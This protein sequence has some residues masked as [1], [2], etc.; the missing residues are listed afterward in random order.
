MERDRYTDIN[1]RI[2]LGQVLVGGPETILSQIKRLHDEVGVG[3]VELIFSTGEKE[4]SLHAIQ[5]FGTK[6]LP[7]L[8]E[9]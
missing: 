6:V 2:E 3:V 9:M 1:D 8:H 4:K 5:L 7:R